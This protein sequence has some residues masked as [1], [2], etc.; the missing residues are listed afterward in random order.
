MAAN[1]IAPLVTE[2]M[3]YVTAAAAAYGGAVLAKTRDKAADATVG[4]GVHILQRVF[5]RK[6]AGEPLPEPLADMVANPGDA[7]FQAALKVAIRKALE[8]DAA[9]LAEVRTMIPSAPMIVGPGSAVFTGNAEPK[10]E[11]KGI[12]IGQVAGDVYVHQGEADPPEP[13]LP[14]G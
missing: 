6:K 9:M 11:S 2:A 10:A 13:G 8:R 3:P 4:A 7:E 1:D 14:Q 12:A 5:G